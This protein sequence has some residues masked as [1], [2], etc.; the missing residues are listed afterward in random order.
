MPVS[1]GLSTSADVYGTAERAL[2]EAR[3]TG[4]HRAHLESLFALL[5]AVVVHV[6]WCEASLDWSCQSDEEEDKDEDPK[7]R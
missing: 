6:Y 3:L 2:R 7:G 5:P 1:G 4:S